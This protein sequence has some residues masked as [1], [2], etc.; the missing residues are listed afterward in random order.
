MHWSFQVAHCSTLCALN[1]TLRL[2][3]SLLEEMIE[4]QSYRGNRSNKSSAL[5]EMVRHLK[6]SCHLHMRQRVR[7]H[8]CKI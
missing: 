1:Q 6:G 5:L 7:V 3:S 8:A 4:L 2:F